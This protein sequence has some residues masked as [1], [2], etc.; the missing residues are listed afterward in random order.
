MVA[1]DINE[2]GKLDVLISN[3]ASLYGPS[4]PGQIVMSPGK[5]DGTFGDPIYIT[6]PNISFNFAVLDANGDGHLDL[7]VAETASD[8]V[9]ILQGDGTGNFRLTGSFAVGH[10]PFGI[11]AGDFN[12]DGKPDLAVANVTSL[13]RIGSVTIL[14]NV[15]K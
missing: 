6:T 12:R 4:S 7:A 1:A 2:D 15:T 14:T 10:D 11:A 3:L 8:D 5:G 9:A 13:S